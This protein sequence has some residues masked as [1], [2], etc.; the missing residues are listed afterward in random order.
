MWGG[1]LDFWCGAN[2]VE[3]EP[4]G[5]HVARLGGLYGFAGNHFPLL[6]LQQGLDGYRGP[7]PR[8]F[9]SAIGVPGLAGL[10]ATLF[11]V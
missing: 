5:D 2:S 7:M 3:Y 8:S 10:V 6:L 4:D 9:G 11:W 1:A